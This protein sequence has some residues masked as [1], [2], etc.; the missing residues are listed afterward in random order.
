MR[1]ADI[2]DSEMVILAAECVGRQVPIPH[3][4]QAHLGPELIAEIQTP[5]ALNE[6]RDHE[7]AD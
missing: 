4:I 3:E 7:N 2:T 5:G 6:H 1:Y